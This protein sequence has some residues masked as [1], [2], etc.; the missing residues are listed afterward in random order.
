MANKLQLKPCVVCGVLF[1]PTGRDSM[2]ARTRAQGRWKHKRRRF[3]GSK[4]RG[5]AQRLDPNRRAKTRHGAL[6]MAYRLKPKA[7]C[8][9]CGETRS[10]QIHHKDRDYMNNAMEN[11]ER[12]CRWC[13][14]REHAAENKARAWRGWETRRAKYGPGGHA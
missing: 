5:L 9:R 12:L 10:S 14:G 2:S 11:L 3:C 4:C 6:K 13:H 8:E 1:G 7:P